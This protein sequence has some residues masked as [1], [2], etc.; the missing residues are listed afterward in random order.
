MGPAEPAG[1]QDSGFVTEYL[2]PVRIVCTQ[3]AVQKPEHLLEPYV[4]QVSTDEPDF[5]YANF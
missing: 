4:G 5:Y 3:G 1:P 2:T